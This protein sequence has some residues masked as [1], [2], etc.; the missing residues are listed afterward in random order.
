MPGLLKAIDVQDCIGWLALFEGCIAVQWAGAQEAHFIW[1]GRR[2]TGKR[3]ATSLVVKLL[4][5]A[6]DLW[7]HCNQVKKH[8]ETAQD[9]ACHNAIMLPTPLEYAFGLSGLPRRDWRLFKGPLLSS[10]L[11]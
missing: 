2:N 11:F 8:V 1:A 3:W 4:E 10:P 6:W 7:D 9:I 5:V